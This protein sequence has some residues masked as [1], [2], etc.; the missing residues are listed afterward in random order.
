MQQPV[1]MYVFFLY[2]PHYRK[3]FVMV[4]GVEHQ[5]IGGKHYPLRASVASAVA[6][7]AFG[8]RAPVFGRQQSFTVV[9]ISS[10]IA[11]FVFGRVVFV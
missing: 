10:G 9:E 11:Q 5:P 8:K 2:K 7:I 6:D 4:V 1:S 3:A